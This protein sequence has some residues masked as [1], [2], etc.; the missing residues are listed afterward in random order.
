MVEP[1]VGEECQ[2]LIWYDLAVH[3]T[4]AGYE[5]APSACRACERFNLGRRK[6]AQA[7]GYVRTSA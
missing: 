6:I 3:Q 5:F 1:A 4:S 2:R 7:L